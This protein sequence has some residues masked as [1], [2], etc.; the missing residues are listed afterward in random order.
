VAAGFLTL[1]LGEDVLDL[2]DLL[3][4]EV[5]GSAV[6]VDLGD[7]ADKDGESPTDTLDNAESERNLVLA[8][9]VGVEHTNERLE[10]SSSGQ[11]NAWCLKEMYK[12][13]A[14]DSARWLRL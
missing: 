7:L 6:N 14:S 4:V 11:N 5:A 8:V 12:T 2:V 3:L 10:F 9:N 1:G 13:S